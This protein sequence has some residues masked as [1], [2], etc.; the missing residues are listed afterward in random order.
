MI[1]VVVGVVLLLGALGI[2]AAAIVHNQMEPSAATALGVPLANAVSLAVAL[3]AVVLL[4]VVYRLGSRGP[5][6]RAAIAFGLV[7]LV[8]LAVLFPFADRGLLSSVR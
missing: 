8:A 2:T 6:A 1:G 3:L 7:C 4:L 5:G